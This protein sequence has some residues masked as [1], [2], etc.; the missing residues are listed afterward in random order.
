[1]SG[2]EVVKIIREVQE[3][4]KHEWLPVIFL[5][6]SNEKND[7]FDRCRN[8]VSKESVPYEDMIISISVSIGFVIFN[9]GKESKIDLV[10]TQT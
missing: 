3:T 10:K 6:A 7:I 1:M 9:G 4:Q 2:F 5:S 8:L